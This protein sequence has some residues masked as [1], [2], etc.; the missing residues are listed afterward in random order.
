MGCGFVNHPFLSEF[1]PLLS[2]LRV[3]ALFET[4][5]VRVKAMW[6]AFEV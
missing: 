6:E 5:M 2:T 4:L 3:D 1:D